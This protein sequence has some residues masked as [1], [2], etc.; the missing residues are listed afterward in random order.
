MFSPSET[1]QTFSEAPPHAQGL[2]QIHQMSQ[3]PPAIKE[4][5]LIFFFFQTNALKFPYQCH[6]KQTST[7]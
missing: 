4:H 1:H 7:Q 5:E 6:L 3:R 2:V